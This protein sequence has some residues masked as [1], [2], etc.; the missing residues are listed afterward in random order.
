MVNMT[1]L[2]DCQ[3]NCV[4]TWDCDPSTG[5]CSDPGTGNGAYTSS[6]DCQA[7]CAVER[8][9]RMKFAIIFQFTLIQ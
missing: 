3:T 4:S 5:T 2:T 8:Y 9:K 7:V 6:A 1:S